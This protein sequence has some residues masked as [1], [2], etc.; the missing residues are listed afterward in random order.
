MNGDDSTGAA[1][2]ASSDATPAFELKGRMTTLTVLRLRTVDVSAISSQLDE[3]VASAPA[4]FRY[5][6]VIIDLQDLDGGV[7]FEELVAALRRRELIPVGVQ[8]GDETQSARA[9]EQG[10][11]VFTA[12]AAAPDPKREAAKREQANRQPAPDKSSSMLV[13]Q[14]VRSGQQLYAR[15]GDL[16]VLAPVSA[17]AELL[18]DGHIHVYGPLRGRALAG[19]RGDRRARI[20]CQSLEA[21][22]VAIAGNYQV[23]EHIR[24][25]QRGRQVQI[26]LADDALCIDSL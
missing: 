11:G 25:A 26:Y 10:L 16:V 5:L 9:V 3:K 24:D 20:F 18:A 2:N 6:P 8:G 7:P 12:G 4:M 14:P 21:E 23:S 17:G 13:S 19:V 15:A 22:L 1:G